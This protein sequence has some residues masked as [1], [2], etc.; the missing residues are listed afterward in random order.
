MSENRRGVDSQRIVSY[1]VSSFL[2]YSL[3][4]TIT[5]SADFHITYRIAARPKAMLLC[6]TVK[7]S[8][9]RIYNLLYVN[10][11]IKSSQ[12]KFIFSIAE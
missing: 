5:K 10:T 7:G 11:C 1:I 2:H 9:V 4:S 3:F 6:V 8:E 12:V